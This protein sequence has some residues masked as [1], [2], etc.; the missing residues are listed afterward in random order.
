MYIFVWFFR[1]V[2]KSIDRSIDSEIVVVSRLGL[3][4]FVE[5]YYTYFVDD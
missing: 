3:L 1:T 5:N 4:L 2:K